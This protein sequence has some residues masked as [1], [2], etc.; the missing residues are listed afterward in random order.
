MYPQDTQEAF[1]LVQKNVGFLVLRQPFVWVFRLIVAKANKKVLI[2][3]SFSD[4]VT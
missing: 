2:A 1:C 3:G 4:S